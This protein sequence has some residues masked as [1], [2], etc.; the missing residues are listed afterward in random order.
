[1][2]F[3]AA[4]WKDCVKFKTDYKCAINFAWQDMQ[5]HVLVNV[6]INVRKINN[7]VDFYFQTPAQIPIEITLAVD[8]DEEDP[9]QRKGKLVRLSPAEMKD[10]AIIA[11]E[12]DV[13]N[14]AD[15]EV[16]KQWKRVLLS[17]TGVFFA[18]EHDDDRHFKANQIR[19]NFGE[20][21]A[22]MRLSA[23]QRVCDIAE[24]QA[25]KEKTTGPIGAK[26][27]AELYRSKLN[28]AQTSD[29]IT[30]G[31]VDKALT[32]SSRVLNI[33]KVR[34]LLQEADG[35]AHGNNPLDSVTKL[36][37]VV[38]KAKTAPMIEWS[39][40]LILDLAKSG[41]LSAEQ[42]GTRAIEGKLPGQGG[43]G[44]V[45][46]MMFKLDLKNYLLSTVL[47]S[48]HW[49]S[50]HKE[51]IRIAFDS[52]ESTREKTGHAFNP[53]FKPVKQGWKAGIPKSADVFINL[54]E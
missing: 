28:M 14:G 8:K 34:K 25:R 29:K 9:L 30:D 11:V 22:T 32:I 42:C 47:D 54:I 13:S 44:L 49:D 5:N 24:F 4:A 53:T 1:A 51:V 18:A 15:D 46:L 36:Q 38:D 20:N 41:A 39:V 50:S 43:K 37:L 26:G 33:P 2:P 23:L 40:E 3:D 48:K 19:E 10:A 31:F 12:R 27:I 6:P 21:F 7:L 45:D 52:L 16:I 35:W 17:A